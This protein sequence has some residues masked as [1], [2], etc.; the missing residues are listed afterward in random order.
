VADIVRD[1][2]GKIEMTTAPEGG[3]LF[4]VLLPVS[5]TD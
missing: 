5:E 1:L 2:G 4:R 3:A